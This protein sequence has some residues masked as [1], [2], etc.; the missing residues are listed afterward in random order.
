MAGKPDDDDLPY[1]VRRGRLA[2]SAD[3]PTQRSR[4]LPKA[5]FERDMQ[6]ALSALAGR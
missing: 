1:L 4:A 2:D 5:R 6:A 3:H